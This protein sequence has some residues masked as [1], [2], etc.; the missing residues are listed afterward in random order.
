MTVVKSAPVRPGEAHVASQ[1]GRLMQAIRSTMAAE[2]WDGLRQ[3]HFR[4]LSEVPPEGITITELGER[5]SMTKQAS[6]QFVTH[7]TGTGHLQVRADPA[8][9]R[10]RI[11]VRTPLGDR[12]AAAVAA[13]IRQ[14][15]DDWAERVGPRRYAQFRRVL[16]DLVDTL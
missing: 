4:M 13:R 6:G 3:S 2:D 1:M 5:L 8:D 14:I 12:T 16:D 10:T 9:R 15:E 7:L 11:V